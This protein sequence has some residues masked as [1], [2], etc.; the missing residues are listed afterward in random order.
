M[1][2]KLTLAK[3][4]LF[5]LVLVLLPFNVRHIFNYEQV[6]NLEGFRE[7]LPWSLYA[8]D[9]VFVF[10][11]VVFLV[12]SLLQQKSIKKVFS[13]KL[14]NELLKTKNVLK[15]PFVYF[16]ILLFVSVML[17]Q[18]QGIASYTALRL[19]LIHI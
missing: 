2:K 13:N 6:K 15:S 18:N 19:S 10:L 7:H 4:Y 11:L 5:Y 1:I 14:C 8:F 17:S 16:F 3:N 9:A 12:D